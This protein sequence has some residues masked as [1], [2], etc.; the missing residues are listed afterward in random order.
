MP[1]APTAISPFASSPPSR[2][3]TTPA[4]VLIEPHAPRPGPDS[5][6]PH[7][8]EEDALKVRAADD[9]ARGAGPVPD[10][11]QRKLREHPIVRVAE[12]QDV[13]SI[14]DA[15]E[16]LAEPERLEDLDSVRP[17]DDPRPGGAEVGLPLEV[18]D[19]EAGTGAG[20]VR[21]Q[22]P[23]PRPD[24]HDLQSIPR[25]TSHPPLVLKINR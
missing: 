19:I 3:T 14:A 20:E 25:H 23:D 21:R 4:V 9:I 18:L 15:G 11:P 13:R 17:D 10:L 22:A 16:P 12:L 8:L 6:G 1:S 7:R 5:P 24:D 2:R